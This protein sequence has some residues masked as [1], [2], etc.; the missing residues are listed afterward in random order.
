MQYSLKTLLVLFVVFATSFGAFGPLGIAVALCCATGVVYYTI[1][2]FGRFVIAMV[3]IGTVVMLLLP[4]VSS[5]S[6]TTRCVSCKNNMRQFGLALH[7]YHET[8]GCFPPAYVTDSQGNRMHSWRTLLLP[9][10]E[11][12]SLYQQYHL[13]EPWNGSNNAKLDTDD[14]RWV[15]CCLSADRKKRDH[16]YYVAITGPGTAWPGERGL[17]KEEIT[18]G[19]DKT[20]MLVE[21]VDSDISWL[22][23]RD[24]PIEKALGP[25]GGKTAVPA[26]NHYEKATYFSKKRPLAGHVLFADGSVRMIPYRLS[27]EDLTK[28]LTVDGG[29]PVDVDQ[30]FASYKPSLV[31]RLRW[32]H[33]IGLPLFIISLIWFWR[34]LAADKRIGQQALGESQP[35]ES[36]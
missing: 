28:L 16:P 26:S 11:R 18:D 14:L 21:W 2:R 32:D 33:V 9:Y 13:D 24:V 19:L 10:I 27:R 6:E 30:L 5:M 35:Q 7:S 12:M 15:M 3:A 1:H 17:K 36:N 20:V 22:E 23:P 25:P 29:E 4:M 34:R 8:Y 31:K